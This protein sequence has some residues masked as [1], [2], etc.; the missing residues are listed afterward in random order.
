MF[1]SKHAL[2]LVRVTLDHTMVTGPNRPG[3]WMI[4]PS[5]N[6]TRPLSKPVK[7]SQ[8]ETLDV[9]HKVAGSILE[10]DIA[11]LQPR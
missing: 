5:S 6:Y 9:E 11:F 1:R 8:E 3:L 7:R 10:G 2:V 4:V